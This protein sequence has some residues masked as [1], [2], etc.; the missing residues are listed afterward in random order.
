MCEIV[1]AVF[2]MKERSV[3]EE[4]VK[5]NR[6]NRTV[7]VLRYTHTVEAGRVLVLPPAI[8]EYD[9]RVLAIWQLL[10]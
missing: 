5:E 7:R 2:V 9:A 6:Y 3:T 4:C 10:D 1:R 8:L